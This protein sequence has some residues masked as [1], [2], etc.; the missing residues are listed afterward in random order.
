MY[1]EFNWV[2]RVLNA[3]MSREFRRSM[4]V[5]TLWLTDNEARECKSQVTTHK[6]KEMCSHRPFYS[7]H[8][9][10]EGEC[11]WQSQRSRSAPIQ[12]CIP[13]GMAVILPRPEI[14]YSTWETSFGEQT[15][16]SDLIESGITR[17][18]A[19]STRQCDNPHLH[20]LQNGQCLPVPGE[21]GGIMPAQY[22]SSILS[23]TL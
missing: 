6:D 15:L 8:G 2:H 18:T 11:S 13:T 1:L 3:E 22:A 17:V 10:H 16:G 14:N 4:E 5:S 20:G 9:I 7:L 19:R 21:S 23:H 12:P